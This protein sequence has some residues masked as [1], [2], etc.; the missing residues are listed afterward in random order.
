MRTLPP[1][2]EIPTSR[3]MIQ[4]FRGYNRKLRIAENEFRD[5]GN[6]SSSYYPVLSPREKRGIFTSITSPNGLFAKSNL[7]WVDGTA[8]YVDGVVVEGLTL[9]DS[10]KQ[11]VS[12]G[13]YLLIWPDKVFYN[14]ADESYGNLGASVTITG[15]VSCTLCNTDG[16]DYDTPTISA[17]APEDPADGDLWIDT[18]NTIHVLRQYSLAL[19]T[20][21]SV[22]TTYVKISATGVGEDFSAGDGVTISGLSNDNLNGKFVLHAAGDDYIIVT[23]IIDE[24]VSQT[25]GLTVAREIPDMDF[26][27]ECDNRVW[28]CSSTNHEVYACKLGDPFNWNVFAGIST[29]SYAATIGSDGDFTGAITHQGYVLF[30]K[31]AV[32]HQVLGNKPS[33]Y[34]ITTTPCRGVEEGSEK[35]TAIV[36]EVLFYKARNGVC[37]F[38][39][40]LP[41]SISDAFGDAVYKNAVAGALGD[42]YYVSMEDSAGNH[43]LFVYDTVKRFWHKEDAT[44]AA[45]FAAFEGELFYIDSDTSKIMTVNGRLSIHD[46]GDQYDAEDGEAESDPAWYVET[47]EIGLELPDSK[48]VSRILIRM[49]INTENPVTVKAEYDSAGSWTT[50]ATITPTATAI[51]SYRVPIV[52]RRCDHMRLRISGTGDAK[53][54]SITKTIEQG[55]EY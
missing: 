14:T 11:F 40:T 48:Y 37:A 33:S 18:H 29:D 39:G 36:N 45:Y 34:N 47:G 10:A 15:E 22:T 5:M 30:F 55:G 46:S 2:S 27:T 54:Y 52:P 38:D 7:F 49:D 24:T 6:M 32:L 4:E 12:M 20:W 16:T 21:A 25:G 51:R 50:V 28:G 41:V 31:E 9:A 13:A 42:K 23:A 3:E 1:L 26:L 8:L 43:T 35:S 17:T 53:L 44:E 19:D